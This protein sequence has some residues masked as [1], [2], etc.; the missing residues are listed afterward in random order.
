MALQD[1]LKRTQ[2]LNELKQR[3]EEEQLHL[4]RRMKLASD[5]RR[6]RLNKGT[7]ESSKSTP[8]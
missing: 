7:T 2:A 4:I 6:I 1:L 3:L 5:L 8:H